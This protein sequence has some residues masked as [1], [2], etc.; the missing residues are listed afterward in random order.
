MDDDLLQK[1]IGEAAR[2]AREGL[3][4]TQAQVAQKAGMS[5]QVYGRI[6]RGGMMPSVPALR[7]LAAALGVS[8]AVLLDMSPREVPST[9]KDLSP[10]IRKAVGILRTWPESKVAVGCGLLRV[11]DAAPMREE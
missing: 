6:E 3:G 8:P 11:L 1:T 4:L 7:R 10:E 2:T 9:D 5:A